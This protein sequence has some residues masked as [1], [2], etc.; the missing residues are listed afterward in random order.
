MRTPVSQ[1][2]ASWSLRAPYV[3]GALFLLLGLAGCSGDASSPAGPDAEA[4][5]ASSLSP[6]AGAR[7]HRNALKYRDSSQP[8]ATGRSGSASLAARALLGADGITRLTLTT[9]DLDDPAGAPGHISKAQVKVFS[10]GEQIATLNF[11]DLG[12]ATVT[13]DFPGLGRGDELRVQANVRGIDGHRTDVVTVSETV[14]L[15]ASLRV[16]L[17]APETLPVG[18]PSPITATVTEVGGDVGARADCELYAD[19]V[20]VDRAEG[21][22]VDAGDAVTCAFTYTPDRPGTVELEARVVTDGGDASSQSSLN[23][24]SIDQVVAVDPTPTVTFH[25]TARDRAVTT[26]S[27]LDYRWTRPDG[28]HKEYA[29]TVT[30]TDR[31]QTVAVNASL[32]RAAAFPLAD[33]E[34]ELVSSNV[35]WHEEHWT[36]L[37]GTPDASGALCSTQEVGPQGAVFHL[38]TANGATSFGY[39]RFAGTVTYHAQG[40]VRT[41]DGVGGLLSGYT[42]NDGYT[43]FAGGGQIRP[44]GPD[45]TVRIRV[46][47]GQGTFQVQ[48]VIPLSPFNRVLSSTPRT[49]ELIYHYWLEGNAQ[50]TCTSGEVRESGRAGE[51]AG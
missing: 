16:E 30:S 21:I 39:T 14:K 5:A 27:T 35:A 28:V 47:D 19:G 31:Q 10:G 26:T 40:F 6:A 37:A 42:W 18:V 41:F 46:T 29:E 48:P 34:F 2:R 43:T 36:G 49:C 1:G 24:T 32:S 45:V 7:L 8:H 23:A 9:G 33:V 11:R 51:V 50:E 13:L 20:L 44:W 25:A 12:R 17:D 4:T 15:G 38:C 3:G 22:W